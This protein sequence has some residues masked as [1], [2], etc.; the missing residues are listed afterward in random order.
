MLSFLLVAYSA[1][2]TSAPVP[3]TVSEPL[4]H[5]TTLTCSQAELSYDG[6][7]TLITLNYCRALK[8]GTSKITECVRSTSKT[9]SSEISI[10]TSQY[11]EKDCTG[12][13]TSSS[14]L[15]NVSTQDS[16]FIC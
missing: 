12:N 9:F 11:E 7:T 1:L 10:V 6:L 2:T 3:V 8:D 4:S 5:Q 14:I 16:V 13:V 15:T